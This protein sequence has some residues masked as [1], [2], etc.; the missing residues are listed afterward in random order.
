MELLDFLADD[1]LANVVGLVTLV[2]PVVGFLFYKFKKTIAKEQVMVIGDHFRK[3]VDQV[4]TGSLDTRVSAAIQMR[5]FLNSETEFG[6][7]KMPYARDC[8]EVTSA[9]LKVMPTSNLQKILA[10]NIRYVPASLLKN[11]D[12]Q[13]ANLSKAYLSDSEDRIDLSGADFFQANLS[14]ASFKNSILEGAQFYESTLSGS[15]LKGCNLRSANFNAAALSN[16]NLLGADLKGTNFSNA[17]IFN[18]DFSGA[19]NLSEACFQGAMGYGNIF[20]EGFDTPIRSYLSNSTQQPKV[21]ISKPGILDIRQS[22]IV[23]IIR[24]E[25]RA[26][27]LELV[28]LERGNYEAANVVSKLNSE[29]G[30]CVGII[31]F[32]F[33]GVFIKEGEYRM[34]TDDHTLI[35]SAFFST[36]WNQIE[37]GIGIA[38]KKLALLIHDSEVTDGLFDPMVQDSLIQRVELDSDLKNV[39]DVL[40]RW[41]KSLAEVS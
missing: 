12:L 39:S 1:W 22:H 41:I 34:G 21:F 4:T 19:K 2:I 13:R 35:D 38:Q 11:A 33:R 14:G 30:Q 20:P 15:T 6:I 40:K 26:S 8:L 32:G 9:L 5:R 28:E 25:L 3:I 36:P 17:K 16:V 10:D 31:V 27:G 37:A 18:V 7:S 23:E 24:S 29:I